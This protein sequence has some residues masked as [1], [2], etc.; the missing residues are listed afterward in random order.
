MSVLAAT[1]LVV[2]RG[3]RAILDRVSVSLPVGA[4]IALIGPN[5][6]GK[7]TLLAALAGLLTPDSGQVTLDGAP[8]DIIAP[9]VLAQTRAY[10]PQNPRAEWPISVERV[11]ALG[12]TPHLPMFGG[13]SLALKQ[14][15]DSALSAFDLTDRHDQPADTLSGGE[16][17]RAMLARALVGEP[18]ILIVDEPMSGLDPAHK[19]DTFRRLASYAASGKTVIASTHDL[20]M[21][22][23][24]CTHIL[25]LRDGRVAADGPTEQALTAG[26]LKE[27]FA[28]EARVTNPGEA[29]ALV[30]FVSPNE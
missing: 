17:A 3:G 9:Q 23:R 19:L 12:L 22:A 10:L 26:L 13:F 5:G 30:D 1:D 25:A 14:K 29:D 21:A 16:L 15:I 24:F 2:R 4:F 20:T 28:V 11:V 6:A 7:S 8:L 18:D 27:I